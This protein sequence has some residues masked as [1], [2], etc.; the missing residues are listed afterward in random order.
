MYLI[1][2]LYSTYY[3]EH[4]FMICYWAQ[5][6]KNYIRNVIFFCYFFPPGKLVQQ[7]NALFNPS[8]KEAESTEQTP[9]EP[10]TSTFKTE[11]NLLTDIV[12]LNYLALGTESQD[13]KFNVKNEP[14]DAIGKKTALT[15]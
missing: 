6:Y 1:A 9:A 15:D 4:D 12:P 7:A 10:K 11:D 14:F 8:P 13:K 2:C 3:M 5:I